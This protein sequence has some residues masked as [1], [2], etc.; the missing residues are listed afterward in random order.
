MVNSFFVYGTL[1]RG[2]RNVGI[3]P[4]KPRSVSSGWVHGQLFARADYPAMI[5]GNDHVLGELW[6]FE[7]PD[8]DKV[9]A[10]LDLLEGTNQPGQID[11]YQRIVSP[12]YNLRGEQVTQAFLYF[13]QTDPGQE[14]FTRTVGEVVS[15]P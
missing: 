10:A 6:T 1:K 15:W 14:G 9:V 7:P 3:W 2:Q 13:Y 5:A 8:V 12:V 11:L 4:A